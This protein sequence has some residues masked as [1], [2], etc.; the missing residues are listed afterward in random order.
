MSTTPAVPGFRHLPGDL[1]PVSPLAEGLHSTPLLEAIALAARLGTDRIVFPA[2]VRTAILEHLQESRH[3][4]GGILLGDVHALPE[5]P[6][7][8]PFVTLVTAAVP[9]ATLTSGP[10]SLAMAG[11]VWRE[12]WPGL[13][14]GRRVVGWYHSHPD[15][16]VFFSGTDRHTQ[17]AF[18]PAP[19]SIGLVV[20]WVRH[21]SG[22]F[23]GA[24]SVRYRVEAGE[25][26][27]P[28]YGGQGAPPPGADRGA[29]D[30][31]R[32]VELPRAEKD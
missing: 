30:D 14:V 1:P 22:V 12:G 11:S 15:L 16:G 29:E 24:D 5:D 28:L 26:A 8:Y 23:T 17:R 7:P 18:F 21:R 25:D 19:Y 31:F 20:D 10:V 27:D 6:D 4:R 3:E 2:R 32:V 13:D 9:A